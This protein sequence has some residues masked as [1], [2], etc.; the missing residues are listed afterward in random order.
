M[1][2]GR[3]V[4]RRR[5]YLFSIPTYG[6]NDR[7]SMWWREVHR[8][9]SQIFQ[10]QLTCSSSNQKS[11]TSQFCHS[12]TR[13]PLKAPSPHTASVVIWN[14]SGTV[15]TVPDPFDLSS[16]TQACKHMRCI[17]VK[18]KSSSSNIFR[19]NA[20]YQTPFANGSLGK[21]R[22]LVGWRG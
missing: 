15:S 12:F 9:A 3:R 1:W 17:R 16:V 19:L 10:S 21:L 13:C 2:S 22:E 20:T 8:Q 11:M 7:A 5:Y 6:T 4:F 18:P 14:N